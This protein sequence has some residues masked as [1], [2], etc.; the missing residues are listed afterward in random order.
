LGLGKLFVLLEEAGLSLV[1]SSLTHCN[2]LDEATGLHPK[3]KDLDWPLPYCHNY[4]I[5]RKNGLE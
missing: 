2:Y 3:L 1:Q 5:S 4:L